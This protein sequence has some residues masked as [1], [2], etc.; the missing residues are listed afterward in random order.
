MLDK[1]VID[2][3]TLDPYYLVLSQALHVIMQTCSNSN[4]RLTRRQSWRPTEQTP[5]RSVMP[6]QGPKR[7]QLAL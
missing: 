6:A 1:G 2:L 5:G 7:S 4:G 3:Q